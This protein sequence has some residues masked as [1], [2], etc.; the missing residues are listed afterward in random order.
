MSMTPIQRIKALLGESTN[1]AI[2]EICLDDAK[3]EFLS[4]TGRNEVPVPAQ[5]LVE[6][7]A[8]LRYNQ[9]GNEGLSS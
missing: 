8:I 7:L 1:D 3:Q 2:L 4:Y 9:L 6:Q 5:Y